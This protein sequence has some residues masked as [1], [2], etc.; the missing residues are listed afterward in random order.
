[1]LERTTAYVIYGS[2]AG[3]PH[4][5]LLDKNGR[6]CS[7]NP[8][9]V[10]YGLWVAEPALAFLQSLLRHWSL[11]IRFLTE[12]QRDSI[13]YGRVHPERKDTKKYKKSA[14][15]RKTIQDSI[16]TQELQARM[17]ECSKHM[18]PEQ[19]KQYFNKG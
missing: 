19:M 14:K 11:E 6:P 9:H 8:Q 2:H 18:T 1:M 5:K 16:K 12:K 13:G 10:Y 7:F 3:M 17:D 15:A 4:K